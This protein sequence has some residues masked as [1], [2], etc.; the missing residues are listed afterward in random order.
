[1]GL[2][3]VRHLE[4]PVEKYLGDLEMKL[5]VMSEEIASALDEQRAA[6]LLRVPRASR[7]VIWVRDDVVALRSSVSGILQ[8][9]KKAE[10]SSAESVAALAR[11]DTIKQCIYLA[12]ATK[13][14]STRSVTSL[15]GLCNGKMLI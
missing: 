11:V 10:G 15:T 6:A 9:L 3:R 2:A 12:P 8:K 4:D 14:K 7:D 1:M 13:Q 5:Q